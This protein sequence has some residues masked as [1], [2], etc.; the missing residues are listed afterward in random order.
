[1]VKKEVG[2]FVSEDRLRKD[3]DYML[4][5]VKEV[6]LKNFPKGIVG[7]YFKGSANKKWSSPIDYVPELSDIDIHVLFKNQKIYDDFCSSIDNVSK[8]TMQ[9]EQSYFK[10][11]RSSDHLPRLQLLSLN[12]LHSGKDYAPPLQ[13]TVTTIYGEEFRLC[14]DKK[15]CGKG[16]KKRARKQIL[17]HE[18]VLRSIRTKGCSRYGKYLSKS[19]D[20]LSWRLSSAGPNFLGVNNYSYGAAWSLNRTNIVKNF[21]K[22]RYTKIAKLY[23]D[24]YHY[25]YR[26]FATKNTDYLRKAVLS[27]YTALDLMIKK[28]KTLK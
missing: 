3:I 16:F 13:S 26:Y 21:R 1:M 15:M 10:K 9:I 23:H 22:L 17:E 7:I 18:P 8:F 27:G 11:N 14:C 12:V 2:L 28:A 4:E 24:Y 5:T 6:L 20:E 25:A 19:L